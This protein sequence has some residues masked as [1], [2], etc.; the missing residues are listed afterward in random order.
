MSVTFNISTGNHVPFTPPSLLV[1]FT[2]TTPALCGASAWEW[3][4]NDTVVGTASSWTYQFFS[5]QSSTMVLTVSTN[6]VP[7]EVSDSVTFTIEDPW[8]TYPAFRVLPSN[9]FNFNQ[10]AKSAWLTGQNI[11]PQNLVGTYRVSS[12]TYLSGLVGGVPA[13]TGENSSS[14]WQSTSV[15]ALGY[16][17]Y[18]NG[19]QVATTKN[20][21][22]QF[23][24]PMTGRISTDMTS[25]AFMGTA[26]YTNSQSFSSMPTIWQILSGIPAYTQTPGTCSLPTQ[27]VSISAERKFPTCENFEPVTPRGIKG[28][29]TLS[30]V[31][32]SYDLLAERI[33][34]QIG[35]PM[36]NAEIC[37]D[38]IMDFINQGCEW[39]S[40]YAG[41]TEEYLMFD[42]SIYQCGYGMKIDKILNHIADWYCPYSTAGRMVSGQYIDCDLNN[43]RKVV[44]IFSAD[45]AGGH[46]YSSEILFNMDYMFAQ[47]AY[48]GQLMGGF[49]YDITTWHLL[50]E[51][52]DLRK[53]MFA[54]DIYIQFNP[55]S[56]MIRLTPEPQIVS[57]RGRYVGI[58]GVRMEKSI[59][60][61]V[62]ERWVQRYALALTKIAL[63]H[64]RGK[65]GGVVLFGGGTVNASDLM[66]QGLEEKT[67]LEEELMNG[68][69][70]AEPPIFFIA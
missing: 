21:R 54:T 31:V 55:Q 38:Q 70:E 42:S 1:T 44:G 22:Y 40:K 12:I 49:G 62:Q 51:W 13:I 61:L 5:P 30:P 33:K 53:K 68:Y 60:E 6:T 48:F 11:S 29:T 36:T 14:Y 50:K 39:Y 35:W 67:K 17:W 45:P 27:I 25:M 7:V 16:T 34:M 47:Q 3:S 9:I 37:D 64:I 32:T 20:W 52:M 24:D 15:P 57:G 43:Y 23:F 46:G 19:V 41:F 4:F 18:F 65:F 56:Q 69:G 63:A 58:L 8:P 26:V 66:T 28:S 10:G 59:R 2:D